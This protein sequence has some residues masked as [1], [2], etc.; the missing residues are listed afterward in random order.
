MFCGCSLGSHTFG[1]GLLC[2]QAFRFCSFCRGICRCQLFS[3]SLF[4]ANLA[5]VFHLNP[6]L[7]ACS[8]KS[9]GQGIEFAA[10]CSRKGSGQQQQLSGI[11]KSCLTG[12]YTCLLQ[13]L[14]QLQLFELDMQE[15][16]TWTLWIGHADHEQCT[17]GFCRTVGKQ[18]A[19]CNTKYFQCQAIQLRS[20][21]FIIRGR[22]ECSDIE[23]HGVGTSGRHNNASLSSVTSL[24]Q[25]ISGQGQRICNR[26]CRCLRQ[27]VI[28]ILNDRC[29]YPSLWLLADSVEDLVAVSAQHPGRSDCNHGQPCCSRKYFRLHQ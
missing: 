18:C 23:F 2:C 19:L 24:L 13:Q 20:N 25:K 28:N 9:S 15:R 21:D 7:I 26:D 27:T 1:L 11:L 17:R 8:R 12:R 3:L 14:T 16:Q 29:C 4:G 6:L 10:I 22:S 5:I